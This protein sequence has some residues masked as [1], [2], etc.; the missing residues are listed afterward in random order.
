MFSERVRGPQELLARFELRELGIQLERITPIHAV[1]VDQV[2]S[3]R[4]SGAVPLNAAGSA[5]AEVRA[6]GSNRSL[7]V[8]DHGDRSFPCDLSRSDVDGMEESVFARSH[9]AL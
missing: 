9:G 2:C 4:V 7:N 6:L 5:G 1:H 3:G 8:L